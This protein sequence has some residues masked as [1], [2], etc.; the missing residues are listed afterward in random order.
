MVPNAKISFRFSIAA[1]SPQK[2][3]QALISAPTGLF[4]YERNE[5]R[6]QSGN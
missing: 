1:I 2:G 4:L 3:A 5:P 6:W